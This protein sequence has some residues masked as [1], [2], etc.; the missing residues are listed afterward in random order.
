VKHLVPSSARPETSASSGRGDA[1]DVSAVLGGSA[2]P[3]HASRAAGEE[4]EE[5]RKEEADCSGQ[6]GPHGG[7]EVGVAATSVAIDVVS[8]DY[9]SG[10][11]GGHDNQRDDKGHG[12]DEGGE[13][14]ATHPRTKRDEE[15]EE[16]ETGDNG[17]QD[18]DTSEHLRAV[19]GGSVEGRVVDLS[20][21]C[22]RVIANVSWGAV[23]I[24]AAGVD[25]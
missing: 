10:E 19:L 15:S 4:D 12:G 20:H 22:G 17:V 2:L 21:D 6:H 14:G 13:E 24:V 23:V 7:G 3:V 8:N 25:D 18:H 9:E 16:G 5:E 1:I 11:V